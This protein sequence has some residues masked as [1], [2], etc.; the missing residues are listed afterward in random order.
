ML[1][2]GVQTETGKR[3]GKYGEE[4][5]AGEMS[6]DSRDGKYVPVCDYCGLELGQCDSFKE[7]VQAA[8]D[9]GWYFDRKEEED[10]CEDC[11]DRYSIQR[12]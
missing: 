9:A 11:Q 4:E 6:I 5:N 10:Y 2:L 7:A 12:D 8:E 3:K 1:G